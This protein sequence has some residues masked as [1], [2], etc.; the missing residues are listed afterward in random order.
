LKSGAAAA[1]A[2]ALAWLLSGCAAFAD[3][4]QT[5]ALTFSRPTDLPAR[6]ERTAVP[7]FP[8]TRFHCGPAALAT[9]LAD[10][11]LPADV[12]ALGDA[13]FLPAREGSLQ[14]EMLGA[15]R[16]QGAVATRLPG[17]LHALLR[18]VA[19]GHAV[20][21]LQNLGLDL[22]PRWHYAVLV[23]YDLDTLEVVLRSGTTERERMSLRTFEF[24]WARGGRWAIAVLP[25][26]RWPATASE[27]DAL[28]AAIGFER[29]A[30]PAP[31]AVSY[32]AF[33]KRWPDNLLA[34]IGLGN[35]LFAAGDIPSAEH[36][37]EDLAGRQDSAV[38][39][40][41][42]ARIRLGRGDRPGAM[43][44]AARA[45]QRAQA[46]EPAWLA[47]ARATLAAA[48]ADTAGL[49]PADTLRR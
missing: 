27:A 23:G 41:N 18:E 7:F 20:V 29:V 9:A 48:E 6:A 38:A 4:P 21:V 1:A 32:R 49:A 39:W 15:A 14:I 42:L 12:Q 8:Q 2:A 33:L 37:F 3:P 44:A 22:I 24:T 16:R 40:N 26:G 5:A 45:V 28:D 30:Q 34:S 25:A 46:A 10:V 19:A 17:E 31:A 36:V 13:V 11:G 43:E 47:A 35:T